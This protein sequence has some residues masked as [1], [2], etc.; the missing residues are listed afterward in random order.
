LIIIGLAVF[1]IASVA[2][3]S[4]VTDSSKGLLH[5]F[6]LRNDNSRI[7]VGG[8]LFFLITIFPVLQ[9][10]PVGETIISERYTYIPY[11][12]LF[13]IVA[14]LSFGKTKP[15]SDYGRYLAVGLIVVFTIITV[16]RISVWKNSVNFWTD[17]IEHYPDNK[18]PYNNRGYMY[19]EFGQYKEAIADF[20]K[21]ISLDSTYGRLYLNRG[22]AYARQKMYDLA[23]ADYTKS[24][25]Y[26]TTEQQ[27]YMNRGGIYTDV[28]GKYD[29][30]ISDFQHALRIN[31]ENVEA[32]DNLGVSYFKKED[33]DKALEWY[34]KSLALKP[35]DGKVYYFRAL[36]YGAKKDYANAIADAESSRKFGFAA[37]ENLL[38]Q[39]K[40][41]R[42]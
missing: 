32:I 23:M 5:R 7:I 31:P 37:D 1:V 24:I 16:S 15:T 28:L 38:Q 41:Q 4:P 42:Q 29:S 18:I 40:A 17:V 27:T 2:K 6:T 20:N 26:D 13:F 25:K 21:G 35:D 39:W 10:L 22:L 3:Q 12:G 36:V 30:G 34:N 9:F 8:L 33:Y 14:N 19:N 11:I